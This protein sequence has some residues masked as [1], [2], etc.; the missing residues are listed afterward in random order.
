MHWGEN[1]L[2]CVKPHP[3]G[4]EGVCATPS[5]FP[6]AFLGS[7][8]STRESLVLGEIARIEAPKQAARLARR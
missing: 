4:I 3:A 7:F 8:L 2:V 6:S 1:D 5:A